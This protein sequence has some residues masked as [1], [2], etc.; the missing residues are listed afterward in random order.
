MGHT[1]LIEAGR[2]TMQGNWMERQ[3]MPIAV[4]GKTIIAW[5]QENWFTM[6]TKL[7]FPDS[8]RE[9]ISFQYRG[10]LDDGERQYTYVLQ[11]NLLG[12]IEGEG[13]IGPDSVVQRYW[14]LDDRR[15]RSGFETFYRLDDKTYHLSSGILEGHHLTSTM[16]AILERQS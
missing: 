7:I 16:E 9:E 11:Q 14:V 5:G 1:F 6:V 13:W 15:R 12:R 4:K 10:R 2:W 8:D 3:G